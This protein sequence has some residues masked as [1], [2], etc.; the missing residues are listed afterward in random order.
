MIRKKPTTD[1]SA[2]TLKE[3]IGLLMMNYHNPMRDAFAAIITQLAASDRVEGEKEESKPL[4]LVKKISE[5][6]LSHIG[7]EE[8]LLFPLAD[9]KNSKAAFPADPQPFLDELK[10]EHQKLEREFDDLEEATGFY[11]TEPGASPSRKLAYARLND[12]D[13]DFSRL[14]YIEEEFLFPRFRRLNKNI[15]RIKNLKT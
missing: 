4:V 7:K 3:L 8:R 2:L 5:R 1:Y 12:L 13:Q 10:D 9:S 14:M 6:F 15:P 11:N